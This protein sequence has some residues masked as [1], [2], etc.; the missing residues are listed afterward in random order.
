MRSDMHKVVTERSR[1]YG[2]NRSSY[3]KAIKVKERRYYRGI[4]EDYRP[5]RESIR[6]PYRKGHCNKE[7]SD[8]IGPLE[9]YLRAQNGRHWDDVWSDICKVLRGN[10]LQAAHIK[11]HVKD[12]V[13][14]IPHSGRTYF[15]AENWFTPHFFGS[16]G[17]RIY[18]DQHKILRVV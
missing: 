1:M 12:L 2:H 17:T 14:G 5:K 8:L 15:P 3:Y 4:L 13:D 9:R 6:T 18:V 10:G 11:G 7:F 16:K